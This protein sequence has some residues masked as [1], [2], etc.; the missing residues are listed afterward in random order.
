MS[1]PVQTMLLNEGYVSQKY[2]DNKNQYIFNVCFIVI[3]GLKYTNLVTVQEPL[4]RGCAVGSRDRD[5]RLFFTFLIRAS[6]LRKKT[7]V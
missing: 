3:T 4:I 6:L 5:E 2:H 1:L 7:L